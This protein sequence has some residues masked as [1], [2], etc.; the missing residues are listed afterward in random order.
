MGNRRMGLGRMEVLLEAVD[1]D[2]DLTNSTLTAPS[3]SGAAALSLA[4]ETVAGTGGGA[5]LS[6]STPISFCTTTN[7]NGLVTLADGTAVGQ[8]KIIVLKT[9]DTTNLTITPANLK[10][11]TSIT[12]DAHGFLCV[13]VWGGANWHVSDNTG[14]VVS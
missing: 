6:V 1:R 11:G 12:A 7:S 3:I 8:V 5:A 4:S 14:M 13:L 2:L 9:K 10:G